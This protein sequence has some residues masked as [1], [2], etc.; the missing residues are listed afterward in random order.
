MNDGGYVNITKK[1][2]HPQKEYLEK[3]KNCCHVLAVTTKKKNSQEKKIWWNKKILK[4]TN[5]QKVFN[6]NL[7]FFSGRIFE[8]Q[9][10]LA[11]LTFC[12]KKAITPL[13]RDLIINASLATIRQQVLET[14][15]YLVP[16]PCENL[17]FFRKTCGVFIA[18]VKLCHPEHTW[19]WIG[20][21]A[22]RGIIF[23]GLSQNCPLQYIE[24]K[25]IGSAESL[26]N[27]LK[28]LGIQSVH[29]KGEFWEPIFDTPF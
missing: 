21:D 9:C 27:L 24:E 26:N 3:I 29:C 2:L 1:M 18:R 4:R 20:Y 6:K 16:Y 14:G 28:E 10:H 13:L 11:A 25:D 15:Y 23:T 8:G 17:D 5:Y 22:W 7:N 19:H 12:C